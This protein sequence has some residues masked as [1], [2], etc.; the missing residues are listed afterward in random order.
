MTTAQ[1]IE[2]DGTQAVRL[3][4]GFRFA[5]PTVSI[6]R[7]GDAVVLEPLKT[8]SWPEEFFQQIRITDPAFVRPSH[9][10]IPP[11]TTLH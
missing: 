3:P 8:T 5:I 9:G 7:G 11:A 6:R 4:E 1:I 2:L 10:Q